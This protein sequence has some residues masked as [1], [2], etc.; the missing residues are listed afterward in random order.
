MALNGRFITNDE[1]KRPWRSGRG[2]LKVIPEFYLNDWGRPRESL[3]GVVCLR[4][5]IRNWDLGGHGRTANH[6]NMT[7]V[8]GA[9]WYILKALLCVYVP[10]RISS[11]LT[12]DF[13]W[14]S[15]GLKANAGLKT[16]STSF[17]IISVFNIQHSTFVIVFP[18]HLAV[19]LQLKHSKG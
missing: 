15:Q 8:H 6:S 4:A 16:P 2:P 19:H 17:G 7:F 18:P 9:G 13:C 5:E 1:F 14:F 10:L 11:L 3:I 12:A